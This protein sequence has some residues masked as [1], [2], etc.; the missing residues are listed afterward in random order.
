MKFK[1][2]TIAAFMPLFTFSAFAQ[3]VPKV[4]LFFGY[5]ALRANSAQSLPSFLAQG[6]L[7]NAGF[8][9]TNH[10]ALE[11]EFGGYNNGNV[12]NKNFDTTSFSYLLGPRISLGRSRRVDP[13]IH[14]LFGVNRATTSVGVNSVLIPTPLSTTVQPSNGRYAVSQANFAMAAGGG[15]DIKLSRHVLLRPIQIDYYL[16]RFEAPAFINPRGVTSNRKQH[17][18]RAAA[19]IAFTI[20]GEK[21]TPPA[22]LL[23]PP[24]TIAMKACPDG[25]S[26]PASQD[27]AKLNMMLAIGINPTA[28]CPGSTAE[29]TINGRIPEGATT[30]WMLA[31]ETVSQGRSFAFGSN[32]RQPGA[33]RIGL[34]ASAE[35]Y[36]DALAEATVTVRDYVPP[37]GT[38]SASPAEIYVGQTADLAATFTPGQCGGALSAVA[39]TAGEGSIRGNQFD[40]TGV[41]FDPPG[42]EEQRKTITIAAQIS[43]QKGSATANSSVV[44]KQRAALAP[45]RLSDVLFPEGSD[46]VNNCGKRV[47][48]D[49]LKSRFEADAGGKVV[50]V[51]HVAQSELN[52]IGLDLKRALNGAAVISAGEG[53]CTKFPAPQILVK[54]VGG[55]DNGADYQPYFCA[56]STAVPERPGQ[57][58]SQSDEAKY[59]RVEVWFVP[60]GG[61]LPASAAD[62]KTAD[63]LS[64]STLGC[65]R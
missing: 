42:P 30:Q 14:V 7:F 47:L 60:A 50:F 19:G 38:L 59:R 23:P 15:L 43:D 58:V 36:N 2:I 20:G 53:V 48:L 52:S 28:V 16:T 63:V 32:G 37:T 3:D 44:V 35:G 29:V 62:A 49:D 25:T 12:G 41:R 65:P 51:G 46:R 9:F 45:V 39:F 24:P 17:D 10:F 57:A 26:I 6:G 4:D 55:A 56:A 40:S 18:A 8:N 1:A 33:Y 21:A 13:Y 54:G 61:S 64:V 5:S 31:G 27:C 22:P 34:K 11:A